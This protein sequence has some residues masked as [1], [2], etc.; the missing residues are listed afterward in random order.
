MNSPS[1]G[2]EDDPR[3]EDPDFDPDY[4]WNAGLNPHGDVYDGAAYRYDDIESIEPAVLP[5]YEAFYCFADSRGATEAPTISFSTH[6]FVSNV[7]SGLYTTKQ[8]VD[9]PPEARLEKKN[10]V[11]IHCWTLGNLQTEK[12]YLA[13]CPAD[14]DKQ[15]FMLPVRSL[16]MQKQAAPWGNINMEQLERII[17]DEGLGGAALIAELNFD[18]FDEAP[19][20][21]T[22]CLPGKAT[23]IAL[24]HLEDLQESIAAERAKNKDLSLINLQPSVIVASALFQISA[25]EEDIVLGVTGFEFQRKLDIFTIG[26][27]TCSLTFE[28]GRGRHSPSIDQDTGLYIPAL[29]PKHEEKGYRFALERQEDCGLLYPTFI[30]TAGRLFGLSW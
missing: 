22:P 17:V 25:I 12:L 14:T 2:P 11:K 27:I 29:N 18:N 21:I 9:G 26:I 5:V 4:D 24:R 28:K 8:R 1:F 3:D 13:V 20:S 6:D 15:L 16:D 19:V 7:R 30:D 23:D 10:D